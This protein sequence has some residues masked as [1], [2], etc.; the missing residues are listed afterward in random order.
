MLLR[1]NPLINRIH[2]VGL[3]GAFLLASPGIYFGTAAPRIR[4]VE[5]CSDRV[6][7]RADGL[8]IGVLAD[9][10]IDNLND[11]A[12][13]RK[14]VELANTL[15][16]DIFCLLGDFTDG[17]Q[18]Q[19]F[20][21]LDELKNL[22]SKHGIYAVPGNHDYYCDYQAVAAHFRKMGFPFLENENL[23]LEK[24][25]VRICGITD[26]RGRR[27]GELEPDIPLAL[28]DGSPEEYHILLS[29]RPQCAIAAAVFG[30][31][32]QL[33]GH[34][35]GG[36]VWGFDRIIAKSCKGFGWGTHR[37]GKMFLVISNG[38]GMWSGFPVRLGRPAEI[39][40]VTLK[41]KK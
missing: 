28:S 6:P 40:L 19:H 29:H 16:P 38:I 35:H 3:A 33:S 24:F 20:E 5:I 17:V 21:A 37:V 8:T 36:L 41:R 11:A 14:V 12:K 9:L 1:K 34:T 26:L 18:K 23:L 10:H 2:A 30:A 39:L 4:K 31:D 13:I 27:A 22:R 25:N 32:L 15:S 7:V